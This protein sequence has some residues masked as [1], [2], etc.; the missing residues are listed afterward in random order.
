[1][2]T[3]NLATIRRGDPRTIVVSVVDDLGVPVDLAGNTWTSTVRPFAT[4][5]TALPLAV[6]ATQAAAGVLE[7]KLTGVQSRQLAN[8]MVGDVQGSTFGTILSFAAAVVAD[9]T[10]GGTEPS[11]GLIDVVTVVLSSEGAEVSS[12]VRALL[13]G[14]G[15]EDAI[16]D[17]KIAAA[18]APFVFSQVNSA[19]TWGPIVHNLN[20]WYPDVNVFE[21]DDSRVVPRLEPID[22][23]TCNL[24]FVVPIAGTATLNR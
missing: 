18:V 8:R 2:P 15:A 21:S 20:V 16:I 9:T 3:V 12:T 13:L 14:G 7:F 23:N 19:D 10:R 1:M 6:D 4:S 5:S 11:G 22:V 24:V 17:A